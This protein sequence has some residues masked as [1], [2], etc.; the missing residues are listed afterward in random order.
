MLTA[1]ANKFTC[2]GKFA[3][4][5]RK[6]LHYLFDFALKFSKGLWYKKIMNLLLIIKYS[7]YIH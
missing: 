7:K 5:L 2:S 4:E 1:E 6:Y 3:V